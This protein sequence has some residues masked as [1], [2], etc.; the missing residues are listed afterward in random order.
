M[1]RATTRARAAK[2]SWTVAYS[3]CCADCVDRCGRRGSWGRHLCSTELEAEDFAVQVASGDAGF[4]P[5]QV[6]IIEGRG[7]PL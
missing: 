1:S 6:L 2:R 4:T 5:G 7:R 3:C